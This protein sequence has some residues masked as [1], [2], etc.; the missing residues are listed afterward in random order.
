MWA[1]HSV[2]VL[3]GE[4]RGHGH[5]HGV[6]VGDQRRT[7]AIAEAR[8]LGLQMQPL[9]PHRVEAGEVEALEDV[10]DEAAR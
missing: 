5:V 10:E 1:A 3:G 7:V 9:G 4:E 6:G 8:G 2:G